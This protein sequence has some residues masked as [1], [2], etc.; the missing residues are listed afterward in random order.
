MTTSAKRLFLKSRRSGQAR[1]MENASANPAKSSAWRSRLRSDRQ[2][3]LAPAGTSPLLLRFSPGL[4]LP[5]PLLQSLSDMI[6]DLFYLVVGKV[7]GIFF[8]SGIWLSS[9]V[10]ASESSTWGLRFPLG[11]LTYVDF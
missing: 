3:S 8:D 4:C 11:I 5:H 9:L 1:Q 2:L 10:A 7:T 6:D